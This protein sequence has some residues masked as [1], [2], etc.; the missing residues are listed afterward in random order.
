MTSTIS[1]SRDAALAPSPFLTSASSSS[2]YESQAASS[3]STSTRALVSQ[4]Q[5][6]GAREISIGDYTNLNTVRGDQSIQY[7]IQKHRNYALWTLSTGVDVEEEVGAE[8]GANTQ[9]CRQG[10]VAVDTMPTPVVELNKPLAEIDLESEIWSAR[11]ELL[12]RHPW[13]IGII[14]SAFGYLNSNL[15]GA[16]RRARVE[17]AS[18]GP[19]AYTVGAG[20][21]D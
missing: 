4:Q 18:G 21:R 13:L 11:R 9:R 3:T 8:R 10:R 16:S 6:P 20:D 5:F 17:Y 15:V 7:N 2:P 12:D 14:L 1:Q 19:V